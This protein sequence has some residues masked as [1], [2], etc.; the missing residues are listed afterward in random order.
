MNRFNEDNTEYFPGFYRGQV[1][2]NGLDKDIN[3][4]DA[5]KDPESRGRFQVRVLGLHSQ[6]KVSDMIDG[7]PTDHLPWAEQVGSLF[8]GFG[9]TKSGISLIPEVGAWVWLFFDNGNHN[10]PVVFGTVVAKGDIDRNVVSSGSVVLNFPG[11]SQIIV[12]ETFE[13]GKLKKSKIDL[14]LPNK[15]SGIL[16]EY[17]PS[18]ENKSVATV[19]ADRVN[20]SAKKIQLGSGSDYVLTT[21]VPDPISVGSIT[22]VPR[23]NVRA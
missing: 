20:I 3:G 5:V 14:T 2:N 4:K 10:R 11:G 9:P 21:S 12:K 13:N 8:G 18:G 22:L 7:I 17:D 23:Q 6:N 16:L 15:E 1:E 19:A